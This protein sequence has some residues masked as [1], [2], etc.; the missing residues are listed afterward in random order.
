[1]RLALAATLSSVYGIYSGF[2]LCENRAIPG[3][4]EY[5]DSEK[6]QYKVWDWDRPG[7]I[8]ADV[9]AINRMRRE[10]PALQEYDNLRFF[11]SDDGNVICYGKRTPD[12]VDTIVMVVNL[13][14]FGAHE[15]WIH[16][17]LSEWGLPEH[18]PY[19]ATELFSGETHLW[20]GPHIRLW[21]DPAIAP[22]QF[23]AIAP[24][25]RIDYVEPFG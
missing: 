4:E 15:T 17:P 22:M 24:T 7:N 2:E 6:Y 20:M 21:L 3:R 10:H 11:P 18:E 16:L 25:P 1:M 13:D 12:G 9:T 23:Y 19:R 14:P 8:I 5:L